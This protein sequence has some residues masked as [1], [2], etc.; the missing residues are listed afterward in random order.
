MTNV[1]GI[2]N[3]RM[4]ASEGLARL[5]DAGF[6]RED[7]SLL[8][9]DKG[10]NTIF[11]STEDQ[12]E[13]ATRGGAAGALWGGAL[14][15]LVG[16]LTAVGNIVIPGVGLLATGPIVAVLAGAGT[17]A[18]AGGLVGALISAGFAADEAQRFENEIKQGKAV[19]IV[20]TSEEEDVD[21]ARAILR[22]QSAETRAA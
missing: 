18:A 16:G 17:G 14:G 21:K 7:I 3:N 15:I 4:E 6:Q 9:S 13:K 20:R 10:R 5:I 2:F 8:V 12:G 11:T 22:S 1:A 19:V